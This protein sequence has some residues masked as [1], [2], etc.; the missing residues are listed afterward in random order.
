M[1]EATIP[2]WKLRNVGKTIRRTDGRSRRCAA[3]ICSVKKGEFVCLI[4]ASGCGKST[5]LRMAAGFE[6][7]TQGDV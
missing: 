3:P 4:G 5:L 7:A 2:S 6:T 1:A